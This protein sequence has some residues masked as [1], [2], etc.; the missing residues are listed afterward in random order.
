MSSVSISLSITTF[1]NH[2]HQSTQKVGAWEL[3]QGTGAAVL[4]E[5]EAGKKVRRRTPLL[6][7][8]SAKLRDKAVHCV[9]DATVGYRVN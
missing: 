4:G 2:C 8:V 3:S 9:L 5:E 1:L 7:M 6:S